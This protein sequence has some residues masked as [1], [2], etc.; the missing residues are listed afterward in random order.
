MEVAGFVGELLGAYNVEIVG[1]RNVP[2][3]DS[4]TPTKGILMPVEE[5]DISLRVS[6]KTTVACE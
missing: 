5:E 1:K 6:P 3:T 4:K 2:S